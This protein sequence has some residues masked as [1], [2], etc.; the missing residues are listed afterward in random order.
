MT[1]SVLPARNEF[2]AN[3][4]QT[5]FNYTF[6]IFSVTDLNVYI[7]PAGQE[8]NDSTDLTTAFTVLGVGDE[9][10][11]SI[12]LTTGTNLNDLLTIVSN[13][14]SSRT[15]DYQNN[16][17]FRPD[18]VNADFDRVVALVKKIED[19]TNRSLLSAQS[20]Q[21][22]KPLSLP[23]PVIGELLRWNDTLSG[24][25]NISLSELPV[26]TFPVDRLALNYTTLAAWQADT[27]AQ[28]G[29]VVTTAERATG[30]D[31]GAKG[32][33]ISGI[34]SVN[35]TDRVQH[36]TLSLTWVLRQGNIV[37]PQAYGCKG[38]FIAPIINRF[39]R[40]PMPSPSVMLQ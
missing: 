15:T 37:D 16:G 18:T 22:P 29:D 23:E 24:L 19:S 26:G 2:T 28:A 12:T 25:E 20:K 33:V 14:P 1:I 13:T 35:G 36:G 38:D 10:G 6:K 17:D 32:D 5:I 4:G 27:S 3:A 34:G 21:G 40:P 7:T 8:A 11:G 9:D 30:D 31:G 39:G